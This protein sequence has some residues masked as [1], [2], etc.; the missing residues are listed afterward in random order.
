MPQ[1]PLDLFHVARELSLT[2]INSPKELPDNS[3]T[4]IRIGLRVG[5][6]LALL[7]GIILLAA[8][9]SAD[10]YTAD[11]SAGFGRIF[12]AFGVG[13]TL[14][15]LL[16]RVNA[17]TYRSMSIWFEHTSYWLWL[18]A[19]AC[20]HL[21]NVCALAFASLDPEV[22]WP[23]NSIAWLPPIAMSA[24]AI[25]SS[26]I[27]SSLRPPLIT[28]TLKPKHHQFKMSQITWTI[29]LMTLVLVCGILWLAH[30][31]SLQESFDNALAL[32]VS[33]CLALLIPIFGWHI[34]AVHD[35]QSARA[36]LMKQMLELSELAESM[37]GTRDFVFKLNEFRDTVTPDPFRSLSPAAPPIKASSTIVAIVDFIIYNANRSNT[38]PASIAQ[39]TCLQGEPGQVFRDLQA[40]SYQDIQTAAGSFFNTCHDRL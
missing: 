19:F 29:T 7:S 33:V 32:V 6:V 40:A 37:P 27:L 30:S 35:L 13:L 36:T 1:T 8:S 4:V 23:G 31:P 28:T 39:R 14:G 25:G 3:S 24:M 20:A 38:P 34:K 10:G 17:A 2:P 21:C 16:N 15:L 26:M 12:L 5:T 9:Q 22:L 11:L 18:L